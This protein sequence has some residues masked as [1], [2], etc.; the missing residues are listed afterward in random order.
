MLTERNR[1]SRFS[2]KIVELAT[3]RFS[4]HD[5]ER[6]GRVWWER[7]GA[8]AAKPGERR[9]DIDPLLV[10]RPS[11]LAREASEA[12]PPPLPAEVEFVSGRDF[13]LVHFGGYRM[14]VVP[15]PREFDVHLAARIARER[16]GSQLSLAYTEGE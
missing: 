8:A 4:Q 5:Y 13:R 16:Y 14:V 7:L 10:G 1:R 2:D 11:D 3:G 6:W 9:A 15:T 12:V